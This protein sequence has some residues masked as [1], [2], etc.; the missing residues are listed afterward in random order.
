MLTLGPILFGSFEVPQSIT[1]GG[2]QRLA[3]HQLPGGGRVVDA[4][5]ADD[6]ELA[7]S[8]ILSGPEA[9]VRARTLDR[10]RR[11][12]LAWP[13]AWDGWRFTVILS[14]FEADSAE[15]F[16]M[17]Y[18]LS[19]CVVAEGDL[20]LAELLPML[21][22]AAEAAALGAGPGLE[23]RLV[24]AG[25]GLAGTDLAGV[26]AAA[27]QTARLATARAFQSALEAA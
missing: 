13:L 14:R 8:G 2:R 16:W 20:A 21:P 10:L 22:T 18:R 26:L 7:W 27:G 11:G 24:Q 25:A 4:M 5:G 3:V 23:D 9:P 6:G 1:L 15:P 19:A 12:G 17:P